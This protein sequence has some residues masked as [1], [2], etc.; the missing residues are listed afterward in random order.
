MRRLSPGEQQRLAFA[1]VLLQHPAVVF[2]DE[3]TSA[4]DAD[5]EALVYALVMQRLPQCIVVSVGHRESL[6]Q[7][8]GRSLRWGD[9]GG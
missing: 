7:W 2:L 1:R 5:A 6:A 8:H 3:S 9:A 4:L